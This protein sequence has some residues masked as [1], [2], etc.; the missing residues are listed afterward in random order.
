MRHDFCRQGLSSWQRWDDSKQA[1]PFSSFLLPHASSKG[2]PTH[3]R[4]ATHNGSLVEP[5]RNTTRPC[6][7]ERRIPLPVSSAGLVAWRLPT[8]H[9][10]CVIDLDSSTLFSPRRSFLHDRCSLPPV[11][12]K[13]SL[14]VKMFKRSFAAKDRAG[15]A[16]RS[17]KRLSFSQSAK[18]KLLESLDRSP[19]LVGKY[20]LSSLTL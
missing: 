4:R 10:T 18:Q 7:R 2:P 12:S 19:S 14:Q 5:L 9:A 20:V 13:G 6:A 11:N 17:S 3:A 8:L 16:T 1:P 15:K